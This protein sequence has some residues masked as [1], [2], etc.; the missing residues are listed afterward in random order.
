MK[1]YRTKSETMQIEALLQEN[2]TF[3][4][5]FQDDWTKTVIDDLKYRLFGRIP[6]NFLVNIGGLIGVPTGI[7]KSTLGIQF[8]LHL[9]PTFNLVQRVGFSINQLLDKVRD[10]SEY[11]LCNKCYY[12]FQKSYSGTYETHPAEKEQPCNNCSN[13]AD[14]LVL[15]TK[16][17]F[18]LDEQTKTLKQ[19]ALIRLQN[20][21]DTCRQRQICFVTCGVDQ[22]GMHFSTYQLKRVQES[23]DDYLP[24]KR[25]K[26]AVYDDA[27]DIYYGYFQWDVTPLTDPTWKKVFDE[28]SKMKTNFQRVAIAQRTQAMNFEEYADEILNSDDFQKCFKPLKSGGKTLQTALLRNVIYQRYPDNTA[29]DR[30]NILAQIKMVVYNEKEDEEE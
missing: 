27:R 9:D 20:L 3:Y 30:N 6:R 19:G 25:V 26:Y 11:F 18:F 23:S 17:I 21:V 24:L 10:N 4:R 14:K 29:E 7:F 13:M 1:V 5:V 16:M 2:I 15:L 12:D 22:Y 28:Y 8:C